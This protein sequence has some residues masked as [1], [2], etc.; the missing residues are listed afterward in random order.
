MWWKFV[1]VTAAVPS[2][3][4]LEVG[5]IKRSECGRRCLYAEISEFGECGEL[6]VEGGGNQKSLKYRKKPF[7]QVLKVIKITVPPTRSSLRFTVLDMP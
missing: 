7:G 6:V 1:P 3:S 5:N 4:S 2:E